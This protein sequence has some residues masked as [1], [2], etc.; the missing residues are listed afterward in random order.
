M[1]TIRNR[2]ARAFSLYLQHVF[3]IG[4]PLPRREVESRIDIASSAEHVW[5]VLTDTAAYSVWNPF[6]CELTGPLE[7]GQRITVSLGKEAKT[8]RMVFH[9]R[10]ITLRPGR[11]LRWIGRLWGLPGFFTG[12]HDFEI[13]DTGKGVS[14][15]QKE[16]F[17]GVF[18]W[19]YDVEPVC[20][21]FARMNE[22]LKIRVEASSPPLVM[23]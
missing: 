3:R 18:L 13:L 23:P 8:G 4:V 7:V 21:E 1:K 5:S 10:V 20:A 14:F 9:P 2:A 11:R 12:I 19:I 6:I 16:I 15:R 22:A 17:S